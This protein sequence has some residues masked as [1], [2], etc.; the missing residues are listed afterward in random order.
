MLTTP[1]RQTG[2]AYLRRRRRL[3]GRHFLESG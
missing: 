3:A 2:R 1:P